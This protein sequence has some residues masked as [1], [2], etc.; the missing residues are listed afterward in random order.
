LES[1]LNIQFQILNLKHLSGW[2]GGPGAFIIYHFTFFIW[3]FFENPLAKDSCRFEKIKG[4]HNQW[5]NDKCE[6]INEK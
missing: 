4:W 6:M 2:E 5:P 3:S 1:Q